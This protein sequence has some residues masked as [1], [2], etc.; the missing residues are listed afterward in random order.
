M[1]SNY[2]KN[3]TGDVETFLS[4]K[5]LKDG[6]V[7][8]WNNKKSYIRSIG[9]IG[10][11][12]EYSIENVY[13]VNILK[14]SLLSVSQI[15]D[16]GNKVKFRLKNYIVTNMASQDVILGQK[17]SKTCMWLMNPYFELI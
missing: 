15:F 11:L 10:K 9:R 4:L 5:A 3:M 17:E 16:K 13:Y 6:G 1:D 7:S 2:S 12:L 14:F 8:F